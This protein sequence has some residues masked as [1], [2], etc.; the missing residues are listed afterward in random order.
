MRDLNPTL[1]TRV[2]QLVQSKYADH[3]NLQ[4]LVNTIIDDDTDFEHVITFLDN[5]PSLLHRQF[6]EDLRG[7]FEDVL[8][9]RLLEV[10]QAADGNPIDL[11]TAPL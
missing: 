9:I 8:R 2:S 3:H 1:N 5:A 4:D 11:Y 6:A 7:V 10:Q